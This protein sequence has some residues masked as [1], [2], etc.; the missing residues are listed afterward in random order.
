M[1]Q[2]HFRAGVDGEGVWLANYLY[3]LELI[4]FIVICLLCPCFLDHSAA[5]LHVVVGCTR[6]SS[7]R[8]QGLEHHRLHIRRHPSSPETYTGTDINVNNCLTVLLGDRS[9]LTGIGSGKP[10]TQRTRRPHLRLLQRPW[11]P[12]GPWRAFRR[13]PVYTDDL[14][15]GSQ[16]PRRSTLPGYRSLLF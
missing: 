4:D 10:W 9:A 13:L 7:R 1:E 8:T 2:L 3:F 16:I 12:R 5:M 11:Q 6:T 15:A 14:M